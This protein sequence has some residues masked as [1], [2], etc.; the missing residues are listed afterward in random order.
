VISSEI[1][2]TLM[3]YA[4]GDL[5]LVLGFVISAV[6]FA[7]FAFMAIDPV[8]NVSVWHGL[9]FTA[10]AFFVATIVTNYVGL[11]DWIFLGISGYSLGALLFVLGMGAM[12][13][14]MVYNYIMSEGETLVR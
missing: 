4:S 7:A 5:F 14:V 1:F 12:I 8:K 3:T 9:A 11:A 2:D 13:S 6:F 10:A